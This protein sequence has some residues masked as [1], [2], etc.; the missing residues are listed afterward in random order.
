LKPIKISIYVINYLSNVDWLLTDLR[1]TL[2]YPSGYAFTRST[3][4]PLDKDQFAI[5]VLNKGQSGVIDIVGQVS[6]NLNEGKIFRAEI[7][8]WKDGRY[9]PL[10]NIEKGTK[11]VKPTVSI[12]QT[13]N[14][15]ANL[16]R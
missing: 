3:P 15:D 16:C 1:I 2:G 12:R 11:I 13:I 7:G 5:P 8:M 4:Q 10:K 6:G 14:G 9:I